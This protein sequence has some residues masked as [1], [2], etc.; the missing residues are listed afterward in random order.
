MTQGSAKLKFNQLVEQSDVKG[1]LCDL[2]RNVDQLYKHKSL[3]FNNDDIIQTKNDIYDA[4]LNR[5]KDFVRI[6]MFNH[7]FEAIMFNDQQYIDIIRFG[8]GDNFS[9]INVDTTFNLRQY[10]VTLITYRKL[11]LI[12]AKTKKHPTFI[13]PI[14]IHTRKDKKSYIKL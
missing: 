3:E 9:I 11:S 13:G 5:N 10:Y 12:D 6:I 7:G 1:P 8:S 2:P 4:L 14:M